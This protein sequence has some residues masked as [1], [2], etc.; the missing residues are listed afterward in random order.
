MVGQDTY[1]QHIG[2]GEDDV[3]RPLDLGA[4]SSGRIAIEGGVAKVGKGSTRQLPQTAK[5]ILRQRFGR[6]YI[7]GAGAGIGRQRIQYRQVIAQGL[8]AGSRRGDNHV[9]AVSYGIYR[10]GLMKI[11]PV[12][13]LVAE[14]TLNRRM[15]RL[16]QLAVDR[17]A[18]RDVLYMDEPTLILRKRSDLFEKTFGQG[19]GRGR[20]GHDGYMLAHPEYESDP[21]A[22][23]WLSQYNQAV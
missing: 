8:A 16:F 3:R 13:T 2:I 6:K 14:C 9:F 20:S 7:Q 23:A 15:E 19:F 1:V 18:R 4:L 10:Y 21:V 5:L 17:V 22:R 11:G 12:Q